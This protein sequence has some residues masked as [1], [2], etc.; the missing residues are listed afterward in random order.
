MS[1]WDRKIAQSIKCLLHKHEVLSLIPSTH[2][3]EKAMSGSLTRTPILGTPT[4]KA[5]WDLLAI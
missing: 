5:P 4:Q 3:R 1:I 2:M